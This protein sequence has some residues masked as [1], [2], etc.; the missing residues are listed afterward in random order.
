MLQHGVNKAFSRFPDRQNKL[1]FIIKAGSKPAEN[2]VVWGIAV[3][4]INRGA[5]LIAGILSD[6]SG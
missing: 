4:P 6:E 2:I 1:H 3:T 5:I